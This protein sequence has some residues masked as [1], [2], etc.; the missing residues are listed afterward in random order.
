MN[1]T[2]YLLL[3]A[4]M[5]VV[6]YVPRWL[7]LLALTRRALPQGLIDWLD[8]IPAALLAALVA[9]PLFID[10]AGPALSLTQSELWVALPTLLF[11]LKTRSLAGTVLVGMALFWGA[12]HLT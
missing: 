11:A 3:V 7:P 9:P 12:G 5:G 2:S 8:F 10:G 4:G 1:F 6:T